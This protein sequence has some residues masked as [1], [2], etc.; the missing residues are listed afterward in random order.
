ML[1]DLVELHDGGGIE[2][3][4]DFQPVDG[5]RGRP[6]ARVD[7]RQGRLQLP[8]PSGTQPHM[9][10]TLGG[11]RGFTHENLDAAS[12]DCRPAARTKL[13]HNPALPLPYAHHVDMRTIR[14]DAV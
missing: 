4:H 6:R 9:D 13:L 14:P 12:L 1:R 11:K 5:W 7:D 2:G 8:L 10:G 3:R